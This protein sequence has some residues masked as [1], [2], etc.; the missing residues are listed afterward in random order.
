MCSLPL[1]NSCCQ[2]QRYQVSPL[3]RSLQSQDTR[4]V[5][6]WWEPTIT[7]YQIGVPVVGAYNQDGPEMSFDLRYHKKRCTAILKQNLSQKC[8]KKWPNTNQGSTQKK[9]SECYSKYQ[10]KKYMH[11]LW[12]PVTVLTTLKEIWSLQNC[13]SH[14]KSGFLLPM[15][16]TR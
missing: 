8:C 14:L 4:M 3:L 6:P 5:S 10:I 1:W 15:N 16:V 2:R 13:F 12:L 9:F 7:R 11:S